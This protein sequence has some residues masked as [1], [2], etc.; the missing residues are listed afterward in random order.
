MDTST[1]SIVTFAFLDIRR[2][3]FPLVA[4]PAAWMFRRKLRRTV[5]E[6]ARV[7]ENLADHSTS[8][9]GMK[10]GRFDAILGATRERL[11]R[12]YYGT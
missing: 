12:I 6:D 7:V 8:L 3:F 9:E 10:L 2:A 4:A 1:T 5:R 11:A